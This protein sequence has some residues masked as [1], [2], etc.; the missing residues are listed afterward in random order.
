MQAVERWEENVCNFKL[1]MQFLGNVSK[2]NYAGT[3]ILWIFRI[4][5]QTRYRTAARLLITGL[6]KEHS[7]SVQVVLHSF[8]LH[9]CTYMRT[10]TYISCQRNSLN[11]FRSA[12]WQSTEIKANR[13][14]SR[15][16]LW[17]WAFAREKNRK[18]ACLHIY[19]VMKLDR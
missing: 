11:N 16:R 15:V 14:W 18:C 9:P 12:T 17:H 2:P 5:L 6:R 8:P 3:F 7:R 19:D 1:A 13:S 10:F 4:Y